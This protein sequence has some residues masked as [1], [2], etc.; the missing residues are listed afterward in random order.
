[1]P[2]LQSELQEKVVPHIAPV[3]APHRTRRRRD[4]NLSSRYWVIQYLEGR[5]GATA[6]DMTKA[7]PSYMASSTPS[8]ALGRLLKTG[9]IRRALATGKGGQAAFTYWVVDPSKRSPR[10]R[11]VFVEQ[12]PREHTARGPRRSGAAVLPP[13]DADQ[14]DAVAKVVDASKPQAPVPPTPATP[15]DTS[16]RIV[17]T[18]SRKTWQ[19]RV[20]DAREI[21]EQLALVFNNS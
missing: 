19:L 3:A 10:A 17:I 16:P 20:R 21:Y 15:V 1:M 13:T 11:D 18:T 14:R 5:P 9:A 2:D 4:G 8:T 12:P 7:R 6:R